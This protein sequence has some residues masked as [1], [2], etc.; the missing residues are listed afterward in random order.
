M[1]IVTTVARIVCPYCAT[2]AIET[3][4]TNACQHFY[5]CSGCG[6]R[7][8]PKDG[9]CCVFCSYADTPCPPVQDAHLPE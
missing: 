9:D 3:M 8:A 6:R 2:A 7:L 1:G 4:P 5:D